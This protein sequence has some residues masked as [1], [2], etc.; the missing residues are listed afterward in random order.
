MGFMW[1]TMSLLHA[2]GQGRPIFG[3]YVISMVKPG[4]NNEKERRLDAGCMDELT[5]A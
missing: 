4:L 1:E 2:E 3:R 5:L